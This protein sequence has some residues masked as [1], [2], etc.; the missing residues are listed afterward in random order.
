MG[1]D[2]KKTFVD[3]ISRRQF[4]K[5]GT[6]GIA[7]LGASQILPSSGTGGI[8]ETQAAKEVAKN[9]PFDYL[10]FGNLIKKNA[11][12]VT[13][14]SGGESVYTAVTGDGKTVEFT[15]PSYESVTSGGTGLNDYGFKVTGQSV[16]SYPGPDGETEYADYEIPL[17]EINYQGQMQDDG[18]DL[19]GVDIASDFYY[20]G[21]MESPDLEFNSLEQLNENEAPMQVAQDLSEIGK[22]LVAPDVYKEK[23]KKAEPKQIEQKTNLPAKKEGFNL[24][25]VVKALAKRYPP[26]KVINALQLMSQGLDLYESINEAM[27]MPSKEEFQQIVKDMESSEFSNGGIATLKV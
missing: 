10:N 4:L 9:V 8:M 22:N 24:K 11:I 18:G 1:S 26:V 7:G 5:T 21:D 12:S 3:P 14:G 2:I 13:S 23:T 17:Y 15:E 16:G 27:G 20:S 25:G 6:K 19:G